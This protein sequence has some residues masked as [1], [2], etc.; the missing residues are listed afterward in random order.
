MD[1]C[2]NQDAVSLYLIDKTV[3]VDESFPYLLVPD[4]WNDP[5]REGLVRDFSGGFKNS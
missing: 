5:T 3:T 4:F 2:N 1:D